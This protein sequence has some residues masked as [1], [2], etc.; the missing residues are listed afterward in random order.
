LLEDSFL[1]LE[2]SVLLLEESFLVF[3][4]SLSP[5]R[6]TKRCQESGAWVAPS[7]SRT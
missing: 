6:E 1:L 3:E 5:G 2:G 4:G 7:P